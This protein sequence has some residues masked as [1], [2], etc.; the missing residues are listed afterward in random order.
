MSTYMRRQRQRG[1]DK[2]QLFY[3][4]KAG[5]CGVERVVV[6]IHAQI[7]FKASFRI[8]CIIQDDRLE[9]FGVGY[10]QMI[11]VRRHQNRRP[12]SQANDM[13]FMLVDSDKIIRPKRLA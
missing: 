4:V 2:V 13:S 7:E 6:G 5:F 12:C 9:D 3:G 10:P 11:T 1:Q 8:A